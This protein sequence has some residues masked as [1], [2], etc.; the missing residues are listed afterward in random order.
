MSNDEEYAD[1]RGVLVLRPDAPRRGRFTL[2]LSDSFC[3]EV[4]ESGDMVRLDFRPRTRCSR[5]LLGRPTGFVGRI[6]HPS[7]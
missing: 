5:T 7:N 6:P 4:S 1:E 2:L 3:F